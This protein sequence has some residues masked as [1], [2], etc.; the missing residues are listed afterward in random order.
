MIFKNAQVRA[1][2]RPFN[3]TI[4][5]LNEFLAGCRFKPLEE[6]QVKSIGWVNPVG[7]V[8]TVDDDYYLASTGGI[9]L[10]KYYIEKKD[11]KPRTIQKKLEVIEKMMVESEGRNLTKREKIEHTETIIEELLPHAQTI[12]KAVFAYISPKD[13]IIVVNTSTNSD[14]EEVCGLLRKSIGTFPSTIVTEYILAEEKEDRPTVTEALTGWLIGEVPAPA[15]IFIGESCATVSRFPESKAKAN[16]KNQ[17][18]QTSEI[19]EFILNNMQVSEISLVL[20]EGEADNPN[21]IMSFTVNKELDIKSIKIFDHILAEN[22]F[23]EVE[24]GEKLTLFEGNFLISVKYINQAFEILHQAF[25]TSAIACIDESLGPWSE[26]KSSLVK[27][28]NYFSIQQSQVSDGELEPLLIEVKEF[29]IVNNS[30]SISSLQRKFRIG[31]NRAA[32][33]VELAKMQGVELN[34]R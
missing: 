26:L 25:K 6:K 4:K 9:I 30:F 8:S 24:E 10:L 1:F 2:T 28:H 3:Y 13:N 29:I 31:Y 27:V 11:I 18:L 32:R 19:R 22:P 20:Y 16:F 23:Y 7:A 12:E 5:E 21:H 33:L 17:D 14:L 34:E 15:K